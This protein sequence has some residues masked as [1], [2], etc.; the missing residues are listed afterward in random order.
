MAATPVGRSDAPRVDLYRLPLGTGSQPTVRWSGRV[1]EAIVARHEHRAARDLYHSA[2]EVHVGG[3]RF[4][5]EMAPVWSTRQPDR[6][7][8]GEGAVGLPWL[9]RTRLFRYQVRRWRNGFIP[10][11]AEVVAS[12]QRLN[13]GVVQAR[14]LLEL[15]PFFPTVTWGRDETGT[16]ET[17]NSNSLIAWLL[18]PSGH[19][20]DVVDLPPYGSAPGWSAGLVLAARQD[21]AAQAAAQPK[22]VFR[23]EP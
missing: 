16:G 22:R 17:W 8:V 21:N 4:V 11:I 5:M 10:D 3:N 14:R 13:T 20:A 12:P 15:V 2:L 7:A 19:P 6:G 9:G 1:Y 23:A 18:I